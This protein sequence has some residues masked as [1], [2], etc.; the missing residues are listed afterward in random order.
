MI[1][2]IERRTM[3]MKWDLKSIFYHILI[4]P[5]DYWLLVFEWQEKFYMNMFLSFDLRIASWIFNFFAEALHWVF[6]TLE[7]WNVIH[8]LDDF[9]FVFPSGIDTTYL[10]AEF[11]HI[12][13][14]FDLS[15]AT[16]KNAN[17]CIIIHLDFKFDS[18]KMQVSLSSNKK[19][20][21]Y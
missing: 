1:T 19:N 13:A 11:D 20:F 2:Q 5:C 3:M 21:V 17:D 14:K 6:K 15:K 7:E 12:L 4:N 16:K 9:L 10:S 8:Y 18:I